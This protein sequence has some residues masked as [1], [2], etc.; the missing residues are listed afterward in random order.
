[1]DERCRGA[2]RH[3][4]RHPSDGLAS[5]S[6][7][8]AAS[9]KPGGQPVAKIVEA[10]GEAAEVQVV[11][12]AVAD[13]AV[14][15]VDRLIR[16]HAWQAEQEAAEQGRH[17]AVGKVLGG[18]FDRG[19]CHGRAIEA[20]GIAA[21]DPRN[22]EPAVRKAALEPARHRG[23]MLVEATPSDQATHQEAK[24][25]PAVGQPQTEALEGEPGGGAG[26]YHHEARRKAA[27]ALLRGRARGVEPARFQPGRRPADHHHGVRQPA[28]Q[29]VRV[30]GQRIERE[31]KQQAGQEGCG[32]EEQHSAPP[33]GRA[34]ADARTKHRLFRARRIGI[35]GGTM[36]RERRRWL[37]SE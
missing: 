33:A 25:Q 37:R 21:D 1:L 24:R 32:V 14:L 2:S 34:R 13:H 5:R 12:R 22:R 28:I 7:T 8:A 29:P 20:R 27:P 10:R 16:Q 9:S 17:H 11:L 4:A 23:D 26:G 3:I 15:C 31:R 35:Q 19:A 36:H 6:A 18:R 30:A